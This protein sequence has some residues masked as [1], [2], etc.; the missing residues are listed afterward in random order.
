LQHFALKAKIFLLQ[1]K[2]SSEER[3]L[4]GVSTINIP[5]NLKIALIRFDRI[6]LC[7]MGRSPYQNTN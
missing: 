3:L 4:Q 5:F 1:L 6:L 7:E 2:D